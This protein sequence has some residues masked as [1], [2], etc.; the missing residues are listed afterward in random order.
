MRSRYIAIFCS[1]LMPSCLAG[2]VTLRYKMEAKANSS[3]PAAV[4]QA[5]SAA[6]AVATPPDTVLRVKGG[7]SCASTGLL[8]VIADLPNDKITVLDTVNRHFASVPASRYAEEIAGSM[9]RTPAALQGIMSAMKITTDSRLT[10]RK[11]EIRGIQAEEHEIVISV[12]APSVPNAPPGPMIKIVMQVWMARPENLSGVPAL[13][14][15]IASG[16]QSLGSMDPGESIQKLMSQFPGLADG[17]GPL[18]KELTASHSLTLRMHVD[19]FMPIMA[20]LARQRAA[21]GD[22]PFA[23][24][25]PDAPLME[26]NQELVEISDAPIDDSFFVIPEG[27]TAVPLAEIMSAMQSNKQPAR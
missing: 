6:R 11:D 25:D 26:M 12:A 10:G 7:K 16:V 24:V 5:F 13:R 2:D 20:I 19:I 8:N 17:L 1:L 14:E 18:M 23:N 3:L 15:F 9:P 4:A 22:N 27:Y 21:G